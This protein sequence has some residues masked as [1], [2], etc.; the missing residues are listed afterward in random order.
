[1]LRRIYILVFFLVFFANDINATHI[2]GGEIFYDCLGGN[3]YRITLKVYRDCLN[4][5]APYDNPASVGIFN[6]FGVLIDTLSMN[7]PGSAQVPPTINSPCYSPPG[8]VC[9]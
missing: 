6:S 5:Q 1:M 4:G 7:F 3:N 2:V 8:N 9:V